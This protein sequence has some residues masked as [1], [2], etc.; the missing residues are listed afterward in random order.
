M[1]TRRGGSEYHGS[2]FY[3]N[4]NSALASWDLRDKV[5]LANFVAT[6][7]RSEYT[8]PYYNLNEFGAS[9]GG[10]VP[11]IKNTYFFGAYERRLQNSPAIF[12]STTLPHPSLWAGDFSRLNDS[13]KPLV[14]DGVVLSSQEIAQY[15]VG[16]AACASINCRKG[17]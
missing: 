8:K 17:F 13:A 11:K 14:P 5:A 7:A 1:T 9:F 3:N 16:G 6:P 10:P 12:R 15:T 4:K 2:L